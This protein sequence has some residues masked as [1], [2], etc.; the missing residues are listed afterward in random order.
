MEHA[1]TIALILHI[2]SGYSALTA[3]LIAIIA[4]KGLRAHRLAGKLFFYAMLGVSV[5]ALYISITKGNAF[6]LH[7]G[8][9]SFYQ[10][11]GGWRVLRQRDHRASWFDWLVVVVAGVNGIAMIATL[12]VVLMVFGAISLSL[13]WGDVRLHSKAARGKSIPPNAWLQKH[14]GMMMGAFI[15]TITAF[16]VVNVQGVQPYWL[17]WLAPTFI[18]VPVLVY[19]QRKVDRGARRKPINT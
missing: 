4:R 7:I 11:Y 19:Q 14:I 1:Y 17:I 8:L 5:T 3:G 12:N 13:V 2:I 10:V 6:L 15:A 9:F 16:I 18:L